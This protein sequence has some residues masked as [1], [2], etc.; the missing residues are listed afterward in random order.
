MRRAATDGQNSHANG[1]NDPDQTIRTSHGHG[2]QAAKRAGLFC[3]AVPSSLTRDHDLSRADLRLGS[4][5]E[6]QLAEVILLVGR[7]RLPGS[8]LSS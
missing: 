8:G 1:A 5:A 2:V 7:S 3:V 6:R 4:L